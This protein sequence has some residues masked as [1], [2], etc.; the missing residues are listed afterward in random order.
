MVLET[1]INSLEERFEQMED[2][3][4][5][6]QFLYDINELQNCDKDDLKEKFKNLQTVLT[7][8]NSDINGEELPQ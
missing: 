1:A 6:F 8:G 5:H 2:Q 7:T 4:K 3:S